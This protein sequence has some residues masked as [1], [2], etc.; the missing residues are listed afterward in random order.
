MQTD[1]DTDE[2]I[3]DD[4]TI[5]KYALKLARKNFQLYSKRY[6]EVLSKFPDRK[7][8]LRFLANVYFILLYKASHLLA[9]IVMP[10]KEKNYE[11][12]IATKLKTV[13]VGTLF[14][15]GL[16]QVIQSAGRGFQW[17]DMSLREQNR[18]RAFYREMELSAFHALIFWCGGYADKNVS[19]AFDFLK[20]T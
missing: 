8:R 14:D 3:I 15:S 18:F 5:D 7:A 19:D 13:L 16:Y 17:A 20:E 4:D 10:E 2:D 11:V 6:S 12:A 1:D 9:F